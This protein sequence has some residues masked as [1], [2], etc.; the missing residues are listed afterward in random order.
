[1][2]P[3]A[4]ET[5]VP[6]TTLKLSGTLQPPPVF[7]LAGAIGLVSAGAPRP[8]WRRWWRE[9]PRRAVV[10]VF[11]MVGSAGDAAAPAEAV[12]EALRRKGFGDEAVP[13]MEAVYRFALRLCR[14]RQDEAEDLVQDTFL[15]AYRAWDSYTPGTNCR[16]WLFTICRNRFLRQEE[17]RGRRPEVVESQL[18]TTAEALAAGRYG[19]VDTVDPE[20]GFW[21]SFID[22][23]VLSAL[24]GVP[25]PFREV[26]VLSDVEGLTYPELA[27]VLGLPIG[28]VKSRLFR[29]R[30]LLQEALYDFAV[31]NGYVRRKEDR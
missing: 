13:H 26:V 2:H 14:G 6:S 4:R 28:T 19:P 7:S 17:R 5:A 24:D 16:S 25:T 9:V 31:E 21:D 3:P 29:G 15:Q 8:G 22:A 27:Q 12:G 30:R 11:S 1:M 23:Q 18:D 20:R 10:A